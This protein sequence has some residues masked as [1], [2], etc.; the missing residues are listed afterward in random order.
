MKLR[1]IQGVVFIV[2]ILCVVFLITGCSKTAEGP[3]ASASLYKEGTGIVEP[4]EP[5]EKDDW[6]INKSMEIVGILEAQDYIELAIVN[7]SYAPESETEICFHVTLD[8]EQLSKHIDAILSILTQDIDNL[9]MEDSYILDVTG[10][11]IYPQTE[12]AS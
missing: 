8:G 4:I 2:S 3:S 9:D 1:K 11:S 5:I 12:E 6:L 10:A 7:Y